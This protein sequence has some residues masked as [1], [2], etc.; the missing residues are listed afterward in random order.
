MKSV[1]AVHG[2][3]GDHKNTW[4]TEE[5]NDQPRTSWLQQVHKDNPSSRIMTFGYDA[6][7]NE[8]GLYTMGRIRDKALQLLDDLVELRRGMNLV[9]VCMLLIV[10]PRVEVEQR[11][12]VSYRRIRVVRLCLSVMTWVVLLSRW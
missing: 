6:S 10:D 5:T 2:I 3:Y 11:A 1:V 12:N 4:M 7:H 8:A 9:H